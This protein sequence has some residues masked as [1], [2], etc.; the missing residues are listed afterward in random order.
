LPPFG[1]KLNIASGA[2][3]KSLDGH[4]DGIFSLFLW[5]SLLFSGSF[6]TTIISWIIVNDEMIRKYIGHAGVVLSMAVFDGELYSSGH[7][8]EFF[9]WNISNGLIIKKYPVVHINEARTFVPRSK[10][11]FTGSMDTTVIRRDAISGNILFLYS[12]RNSKIRS[13][14]SWKGFI[15]SGGEEQ[16][17]MWD[18]STNSLHPLA[19]LDY[20][21]STINVMYIFEDHIYF[22]TSNGYVE[23]LS[24]T[25][26]TLI[27]TFSGNFNAV[28]L[29]SIVPGDFTPTLV[30][31]GFSL[32]GGGFFGSIYHWNMSSG[33]ETALF[34][35][36]SEQ[37]MSLKLNNEVLYSGSWDNTIKVWNT[38]SMENVRVLASKFIFPAY[39]F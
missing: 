10:D 33:I 9:K 1:L 17:R 12:G 4:A 31:N 7:G 37:I 35:A 36:H 32:Y 34:S 28:L 38:E 18:A 13:V 27:K 11:I 25:S 24:L 3:I 26:L 16:I 19:V 20:N 30:T 23:V 39:S 21:I 5:D 29:N 14:V 22:G 8:R 6:D 2:I 15:I